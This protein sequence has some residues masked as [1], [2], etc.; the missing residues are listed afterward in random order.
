MQ[1]IKQL[2]RDWIELKEME[3]IATENR[4]IVEDQIM[5][6]LSIQETMEGTANHTIDDFQIKVVG[7][8]NRKVDSE[9]LQELAA[10]N[11]LTDHLSSLFRWKADLNKA[12]FEAT[13]KDI[14]Q[15]L[16]PAITTTPGRPSFSITIK[17]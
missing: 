4:R 13:S 6:H 14:V 9:L 1:D 3:R 2:S 10:E 12:V 15:P 5:K 17:E 8:M 11:G 7:R 16:L